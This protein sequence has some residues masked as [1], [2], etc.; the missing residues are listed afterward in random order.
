M[1]KIASLQGNFNA[2]ELSPLLGGRT[3]SPRYK[4]GLDI[5]QNYI[6]T[7]QGPLT[8][9][10]GMKFLN[11]V[12]DSTKPPVLIPFQF[13]ETQSYILEF[14]DQYI[15]FYANN[16]QVVNSTAGFKITG[17]LFATSF[18]FYATR[19]SL[20]PM[21]NEFISSSVATSMGD[22]LEVP[23]PYSYTDCAQIKWAQQEDTLYLSHPNYPLFKL[24]RFAQ[25]FWTLK[26]AYLQDGPYLP[27]N[28]Y[29][30]VGDQVNVTLSTDTVVTSNN[31]TVVNVFTNSYTVSGIVTDPASSGQC[32]VTTSANHNF[33][34]GQK[35]FISGVVGT[36]EVNN[37]TISSLFTQPV[38][39]T[40][41]VTSNTTFLLLGSTFVH[42]YVSGGAVFAALF[43]F[44]PGATAGTNDYLRNIAIIISGVR[45]WGHLNFLNDVAHAGFINGLGTTLPAAS[46]A[47]TAWQLGVY[48]TANGYP[49][50]VTFHQNRL[51]L[52]GAPDFPQEMDF[53]FTGQFENFAASD[54]TNLQVADDNAMSFTLNSSDSNAIQW[55]K[56][57]AQALLAG[58][59]S[60]E[61]AISPSSTSESL[62]P[63]NFNAAQT[64]FYGS[65]NADA[66]AMGNAVL[67]IQRAQRKIRELNF[68][69]QVG[70]FRST[71]M[72]ELSEHITLPSVTKIAVQKETQPLLWAIRSDGA[73]LSMVYNR[74]DASIVAGWTRHFLGGQS[75]A[76]GTAPIVQSIAIIPA[77]DT[78]F[79]QLWATVQRYINGQKI[80]C[81]EYMTKIFD[82]SM[83]QEDAVQFDCAGTYDAPVSI[84]GGI[85]TANP[86][87]VTAAAHGFSNGDKVQITGV[88]GMN[89]SSTDV[90]GNVTI[91]NPINYG[92]F[93]VASAT[94]NTFVFNDY[95]GGTID[96][97]A[98][99][100]YV[101]GGKIRKLVTN[102][103][104]LTWLENE[105]V[106]ILADGGLHPNVVVSNSG[107]ITLTFPAAKVQI[108]YSNKSQGRLLRV[109]G[110]AADGTSIGKT[111]RTTRAAFQIHRAGELS[112]GTTFNNLIP[113]KFTRADNQK[114][115]IAPALV[116]QIEREGVE[117]AYDF[118]SQI[119]FQ[120]STGLPG[121][122]V[123][124]TS[125]MEEQD[126]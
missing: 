66:V 125:F 47:T 43:D 34:T 93:I 27:L 51:A 13:S 73:L 87:V 52:A 57:T 7:L 116:S 38:S 40:I 24:Q 110:G 39:W 79:D 117:S 80:V 32:Q 109:E 48:S 64:S 20:V 92:T 21:P 103:S 14:G 111:R 59:Q 37:R 74:D 76:A 19:A 84:T 9:R 96:T 85:S 11:A 62:T 88:I 3:D 26:R 28:S 45:Y 46:T 61:W 60:G 36:T 70:T 113:M 82:D 67:Y 115:D 105:T 10:P 102:I 94:T 98:L 56:S 5:A 29:Q 81:I 124:I 58:T 42:S 55:M 75:D 121:M 68:F 1:P 83:L 120:Q 126:V 119:C 12:K 4:Q 86:A 54:P 100:A 2:G 101:S 97:T 112:I 23:T 17:G 99:S 108:G 16:G 31:V 22:I 69:F 30:T 63:T 104:N 107:T 44:T 71:D 91:S 90:N 15:R 89:S 65:A 6:P 8:R 41:Q 77:P 106:S 50:C 118:E 49:T 35:V 95:Q 53:S 33:I 25:Q 72:T 122:I 18:P 123:S 78:S 114:A